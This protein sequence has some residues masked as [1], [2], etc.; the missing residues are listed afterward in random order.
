MKR[1]KMKQHSPWR[2]LL[3][4]LFA[5]SP[6][7]NAPAAS[8]HSGEVSG[9]YP[10]RVLG[11]I[12]LHRQSL[13]QRLRFG[14]QIQGTVPS[15]A[16]DIGNI[17]VLPD[18]GTLVTTANSF[19]LNQ[20]GLS[21]QPV[22]GGYT[23]QAGVS[24]FDLAAASQ[25]T[26]L[27][28]PPASNPQNI[29]DDGSRQLPLAFSFPY[30]GSSYTSL[31]VNSDGNL[32][33]GGGDNAS[34]QR[35]FGRFLSG[36]PRIAPYFADLD[37]SV[38]GQLTY[39]STT[40]RFVVT[41]S[42]VPDYA[43][44]GIGPRET[45]QVSLTLDGRIE[46]SYSGINGTE[47]VVGISPGNVTE[48][49]LAQDLS[50]ASGA[51][52]LFGAIAEVFTS[53]TR[54][55]LVAVAQRFYQTH[56]DAYQILFV[57]TNFD[58]SLGGAFA[59]EINIANQATGIGPVSTPPTFD[60][61]RE[62]GS[63]RLESMLNMG[64]LSR[65]PADPSQVFLRGVDSTLSVMGQEAGH[66]FLTYVRYRDPE[67]ESNSTALLGRDLQHWSFFFN[68][69]ASVME[70]NRIRDNGN[71]T[72]TTIAAVERY[73]EIDQYIMGLRSPEEVGPTFLV[74]DP[75]ISLSPGTGPAVGVTFGGRRVNVAVDQIIAANGPRLPNYVTAP[76]RYNYAFILVVP[77]ETQPSAS[78]VAHL[79]RIRQDWEAFYAQ[80]TSSRSVA[81][82]ALLRSL[83]IK[84]GTLGMLSGV[85]QLVSVELVAAT[86]TSLNVQLTNSNQAAVAVPT[87]VVIPAGARAGPIPVT[88]LAAGSNLAEGRAVIAAS[89]PGFET[90]DLVVQVAGQPSASLSLEI[91]GGNNQV[92]QPGSFLPEALRVSLSDAN[93]I[94]Y[95][96]QRVNFA[97]V[98]GSATA[99]PEAVDTDATG[100][101]AALVQLGTT[102][103][104]VTIRASVAGTS[105][106]VEFSLTSLFGP[107]LTQDGV[108]NGASFSAGAPAPG[109]IISL[110]GTNLAATTAVAPSLPLPTTLGGTSVAISGI[111]VPL[112]SVSP[113]QINAQV[114]FELLSPV[115]SV[116][117]RNGLTT[118]SAV[119]IPMEL[120][121][122]G[123]FTANAKGT[124]PGAILHSSSQ[125]LVT[126]QN[127]AA[128]GELVQIFATGLGRV[129][130]AVSS[131]Q[132][133]GSQPPSATLALPTVTM[134]GVTAPVSFAGLAAGFVG[135]YEV[136]VKVP[137]LPAGNAA[138]VLTINGVS[139]PAVSIA[140]GSN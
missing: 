94:P 93:R 26:L 31:Y 7:P 34:S 47:A 89:A 71:G 52:T 126:S 60:F 15:A 106:A 65:Y 79:D 111:A 1:V 81:S 82:T 90:A 11:E 69:D 101:A 19:D 87:Q 25:G 119:S 133:A 76:K 77:R 80:A 132:P 97:V 21:F 88:A 38:A 108:V 107:Q 112:F 74:K 13:L 6:A 92:G 42:Q 102:T 104:Q 29:G 55:D 54:L 53:T 36:L 32:T 8:P 127:P 64:R 121:S 103:G 100:R 58:F 3:F 16:A 91:I 67:T 124:G 131:G 17:A 37:P 113:T 84:P 105:L 45:F 63:A 68:S 61:S 117:V 50:L 5:F 44:S 85:Q 51:Q 72:F 22:A 125:Q 4:L 70:G 128:P 18:D 75:S 95:P 136:A 56:E 137:E 20:K 122:P 10:G 78:E 140:V 49:P 27:N 30:F 24:N 35:S 139:S 98:S 123:I 109:S 57:F 28:P 129:S 86:S 14:S 135:L 41:W 99:S 23:V 43:S 120:A 2:L 39:F 115:A 66:R 40:S 73:N 114:P 48:A 110:F 118:S 134:N 33:F 116:T 83:Q 62:F 130:P 9:S 12:A 59:F 46:F 96:G 138:V